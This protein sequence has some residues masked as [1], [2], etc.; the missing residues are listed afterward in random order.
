MRVAFV[1]LIFSWPPNGGADVDLFHVARGFQAMN[2][3]VRLFGV[4]DG[5]WERGAFDPETLPFPATRIECVGRDFSAARVVGRVREAVDAW[6]PDAVVVA[7]GF[8][9]KPLVIHALAHYPIAARYYAHEAL[10]HRDIL[11]FRDGAPCPND[12]LR[13]PDVCRACAFDRIGPLLRAD[14]DT[15]W[16]REYVAARAYI[17]RYHGMS[18]DALRVLDAAVVYNAGIKAALNGLCP[19]IF[20]ADGGVDTARFAAQPLPARAV[21]EKKVIFMPGRGEDPVKGLG[22]LLEAGAL[23]RAERNDFEV[24]VTMPEDTPG[25]DWFRAVGW[26]RHAELPGLYAEADIVVAP[27][28]WEEPFGIVAAEAMA[29]GRPV[30][31]SRV[32]GLQT[33]VRHLE[34]GFLFDRGDAAEL[35][36]QLSLLLDNA[37][38]RRCMGAAGRR[39][40]EELYD[41]DRVVAR[42]YTP[43]LACLAACEKG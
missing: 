28:V 31:A 2:Q 20:I 42:C 18:R 17:P 1:D 37:E 22:V 3:E 9:L 38:M 14:I 7:D 27:S 19:Q 15:A 43:V 10:C 11:R 39:R 6:R 26:A 4:S 33:I 36:K 41:W 30:C 40:A 13:T 34:T 5:T 12:Y 32:G 8:F 16:T 21:S 35:A 24:H 29:A 25:P 23:L